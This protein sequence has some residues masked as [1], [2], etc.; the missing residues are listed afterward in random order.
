MLEFQCHYN[1]NWPWL[2]FNILDKQLTFN[3]VTS[4]MQFKDMHI[5]QAEMH[6]PYNQAV[7]TGWDKILLVRKREPTMLKLNATQLTHS[8]I[9]DVTFL[10]QLSR[11]NKRQRDTVVTET[12]RFWDK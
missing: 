6:T 1:D 10:S 3:L 8:S 2:F 5:E 12:V 9:L 11:D 7:T 4:A